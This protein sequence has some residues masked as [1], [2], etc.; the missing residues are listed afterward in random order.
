MR[1][2]ERGEAKCQSGSYSCFETGQK[3]WDLQGMGE[4]APET[5]V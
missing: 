2:L 3:D 4:G 1:G 5:P